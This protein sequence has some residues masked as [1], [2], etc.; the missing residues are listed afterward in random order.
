MR[1]RFRQSGFT[2]IELLVVIAIIGLLSSIV[3]IGLNRARMKARDTKRIADITQIR[4]AL[5]MYLLEYNAYPA[6]Q[7]E[8]ELGCGTWDTANVD[9]DGNGRFFIEPLET[10]GL[11]A[12]MPKDPIGT[13]T[14]YGNTYRYYVYPGGIWPDCPVNFYV[15]GIA[16]LESTNGPHPSSPGWKCTGRDWQAE[17]EWVTG[18][19]EK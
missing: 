17:L 19:F 1:Y 10:S 12:K 5:E 3:L 8:F 7:G 11:I 9:N 6:L 16:D 14:C 4:K 15:L 2:L 18:S 13:D